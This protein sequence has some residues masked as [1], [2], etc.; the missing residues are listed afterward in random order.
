MTGMG[1]ARVFRSPPQ[2][3]EGKDKASFSQ[4]TSRRS[5]GPN[6]EHVEVQPWQR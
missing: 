3:S 2:S 1:R 4:V 5:V 6:A